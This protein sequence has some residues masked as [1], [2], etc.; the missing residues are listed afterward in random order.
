MEIETNLTYSFYWQYKLMNS[1]N[2]GLVIWTF[3]FQDHRG[4]VTQDTGS[5]KEVQAPLMFDNGNNINNTLK[6]G[7]K[8][9]ETGHVLYMK[10]F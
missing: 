4:M 6:L 1:K 9:S 7:K 8:I 3:L 5:S 2:N 10:K